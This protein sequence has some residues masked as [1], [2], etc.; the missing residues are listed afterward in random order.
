MKKAKQ[1]KESMTKSK[2]K[3]NVFSK[4]LANELKEVLIETITAQVSN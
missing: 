1:K 4:K 2:N 3:K